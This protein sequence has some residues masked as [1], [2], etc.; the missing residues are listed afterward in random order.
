MNAQLTF[1][2][3]CFLAPL[4]ARADI[5]DVYGNLTERTV[6]CSSA[7]P[8]P[9]EALIS[10]LPAEKANAIARIESELAKRGIAVVQDGPHFVRLFPENQRGFLKDMPLRGAELAAATSEKTVPA[11]AFKFV[12]MNPG[13]VLRI[14]AS[15]SRRTILRPATLPS[16][17]MSLKITCPLTREEAAYAIATVLALNGIAVVEDGEQFAQAVPLGQRGLVTARAPKTE[18]AAKRLDPKEVPSMDTDFNQDPTAPKPNPSDHPA[19]R[20]LEFYASLAKKATVPSI[21]FD[22]IPIWF[23]IET[24][25]SKPELLYAIGITLALNH[26][27]IIP[28]DDQ[29][30][31][32]GQVG[33]LGKRTGK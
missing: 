33:D 18:P 22:E 21:G 10:D 15:I 19:K 24:P 3:L 20:L 16:S 28:V 6:L 27:T 17:L 12:G 11:G 31:R 30:I 2:L 32:L 29:G 13:G 25:L 9:P 8:F 7:L 5:L 14:Y 1:T 4:L 23:H 26:L